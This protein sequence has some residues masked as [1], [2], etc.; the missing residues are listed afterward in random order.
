[1]HHPLRDALVVE[2]GDLL[3]G[4]KVLQQR[5]AAL[6]DRQRIVGVSTRTPCWV[7][8][9]PV[10]RRTRDGSRSRC[11]GSDVLSVCIS[12]PI[13]HG[14]TAAMSAVRSRGVPPFT[15]PKQRIGSRTYAPAF[16]L[17]RR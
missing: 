14:F 4:V 5:G 3:P 13:H 1:M 6:T 16:R 12:P 11:F 8:R 2:M 7:V 17:P 15:R 9:Y 10:S